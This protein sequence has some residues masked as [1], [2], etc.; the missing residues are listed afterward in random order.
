MATRKTPTLG[1]TLLADQHTT[2]QRLREAEALLRSARAYLYG[3]VAEVTGA[4]QAGVPCAMQMLR[5]SNL[6]HLFARRA[7][8]AR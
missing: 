6:R 5:R 1:T 8:S 7:R 4:R 3:T 2:H